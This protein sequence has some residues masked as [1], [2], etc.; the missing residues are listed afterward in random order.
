MTGEAPRRLLLSAF[1]TFGVGG[2]QIRFATIANKLGRRFRHV[3]VAMDD[4]FD[5]RSRLS[6]DLDVTFLPVHNRKGDTLGNRRRFRTILQQQRPDCLVTY[7]WGTVEWAM[8]N[9]P[10]L[11]RQ[12]HVEDGFG[13]EEAARQLPRRVLTRRLVLRGS[14]V[15]VPSRQLERIALNIW[16]LNRRTLQYIPNG[17]DCERFSNP[18]VEPLLPRNGLPV[19]G[20]VAALRPE[21]NLIRLLDAFRIVRAERPC[22]LV[23]AGDGQERARLEAHAAAVGLQASVTFTG[24]RPDTERVYAGL[25]VFALSSDTEQMPTTVLEAMAAGLPV[26]ATNV[27]DV[28]GMLAAENV[29]FVVPPTA[30][31]LAHAIAAL[32]D[33]AHLR[34]AI[35]AA[36]KARARS[37]FGADRMI[38]AYGELFA[39]AAAHRAERGGRPMRTT[40]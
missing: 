12:V 32:L 40:L 6:A 23:I 4:T 24:H 38:A 7:N 26:A 5:C 37:E 30:E 29:R 8:A 14:T 20:T 2:P 9:W 39:G 36:N 31:D 25:D 1:S 15:V 27:G 21:K 17:I 19:V 13:P 16:K 28:Q 10:R 35:G 33:D 34:Q 22:R 3:I 18:N 11:V